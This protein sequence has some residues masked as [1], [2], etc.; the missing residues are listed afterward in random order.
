MLKDGFF[1]ENAKILK[2]LIERM[3][4]WW[5]YLKRDLRSELKNNVNKDAKFMIYKT[6]ELIKWRKIVNVLRT[7][8]WSLN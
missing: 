8:Y 7:A 1:K 3:Q 6:F 5:I 4:K 2:K